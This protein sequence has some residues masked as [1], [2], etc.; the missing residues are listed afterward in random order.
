LKVFYEVDLQRD[1]MDEDGALLV[2]GSDQIKPNIKKL[3]DHA[4]EHG[5]PRIRT[6]DRH[7][8]D[9]KELTKFPPHCMDGTRGQMFI[10]E[11]SDGNPFSVLPHKIGK[12]KF[13]GATA[14]G[15]AD[16]VRGLADSV[17]DIVIEK[18]EIS[19]ASNPFAESFF[20]RFGVTEAIVYGVATEF[21]VKEAVT[22]LTSWGVEVTVVVDAI[23]G[24]N[25]EDVGVAMVEMAADGAWFDETDNILEDGR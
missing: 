16:L 7:F 10:K 22:A 20:K 15:M 3:V 2:P 24:I 25:E 19:I 8:E 1:F 12:D 11:A 23:A 6:A 18:Q 4:I 21:C 17:A 13:F 14:P 9:D 5:I